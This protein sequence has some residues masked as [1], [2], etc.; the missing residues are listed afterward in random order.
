[1]PFQIREQRTTSPGKFFA[2]AEDG[3]T[4]GLL[5]LLADDVVFYGDGGGKGPAIQ[6]PRLYVGDR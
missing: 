3:D 4:D 5:K 1:M 6:K 2:A